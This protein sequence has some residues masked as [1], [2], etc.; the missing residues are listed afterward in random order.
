MLPSTQNPAPDERPA[1][2]AWVQYQLDNSRTVGEV[3]ASDKAVRISSAMPMPI[4]FFVCDREGNAAVVEFLQGKL[5]CHTGDQAAPQA[6]HERHLRQFAWP[7]WRSTT[8]SAEPSPSRR[9]PRTRLTAS[10]SPQTGSRLAGPTTRSSRRSRTPSTRW[11]RSARATRRSGASCTISR[12]WKSTT[13]PSAAAEIRTV[14][15]KELDFGPQTPVRMISINTPH[16]GVLNPHFTDYDRRS[17][18]MADLLLRAAHAAVVP[19][20]G[21]ASRTPRPL[22]RNH[23]EQVDAYTTRTRRIPI[24]GWSSLRIRS[25]KATR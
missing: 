19:A 5:V 1:L 17:E 12:I 18:Q 3:M 6:D 7:T 11:P 4:H 14:R 22:P 10:L 9:V 16:T 13:R 15:L 20:A 21:P 23:A 24:L 2:T 25:D 8:V